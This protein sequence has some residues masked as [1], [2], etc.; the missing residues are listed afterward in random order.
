MVY[1]T[2]KIAD[3]EL[4][5]LYRNR[6]FQRVLG[7]GVHRFARGRGKIEVIKLD[8]RAMSVKDPELA[9]LYLTH[10][11]VVEAHF[12]VANM[13]DGELG[14]VTVDGKLAGLV[15]PRSVAFY[16]K[17]L[18]E[19]TIEILDAANDYVLPERLVAPLVRLGVREL[20][21]VAEVVSD[22]VGLLYV[23]G[24]LTKQLTPGRYA[25]VKALRRIDVVT[26]DLRLQSLEVTGQEVLTKD[27]IGLRANVTAVYRVADPVKAVALT[28]DL[29]DFLYK[30][31]QFALRQVIG[32]RT[33]EEVLGDKLG[34][35]AAVADLLLPKLGDAGLEVPSVGVKDIIL[36]GDVRELMNRVIEAEKTA[37]A[38][39]IKR[40]EETAATRSLLNTAKLMEDNPIL[41]R[42]KELEALEKVSEKVGNVIVGNGMDGVLDDLVRI[43][44]R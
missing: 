40:R 14:L 11:Q 36:P 33:L 44:P 34:I 22:H 26:F 15:A 43:R 28:A 29:K 13:G 35:N 2:E 5:L 30:E 9:A 20:V 16:G 31:L 1:K 39:V 27:R 7:P 10:R 24:V 38:N 12:A 18:R 41:L 17:R 21:A 4:G 25:F 42:L 3:F 37:Q 32:T 23:D 6:A 8:L 19:V